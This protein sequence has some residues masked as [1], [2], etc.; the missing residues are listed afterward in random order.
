MIVNEKDI[1]KETLFFLGYDKEFVF[2]FKKKKKEDTN[3]S[4][5]EV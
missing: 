3:V 4:A 5:A 1:E 2:F